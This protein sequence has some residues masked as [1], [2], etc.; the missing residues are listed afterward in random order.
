MIAPAPSA[1]T[2]ERRP[3]F[4][5]LLKDDQRFASSH[6]DQPGD[7]LNGW[8]DRLMLQSGLRTPPSLWLGLC[9]LC[10]LALGGLFFVATEHLL[11]TAL[12]GVVG[13]LIPIV[14]AMGMRSRR[15]KKVLDQ[16]PG[17]AEELARAAR[18]GRN[19]ENAFQLVAADTPTPLGDELRMAMRRHQIGLDLAS[20][21]RDLPQRT[22]VTACTMLSSAIAVHQDTGG[23][24]VKVLERLASAIRDRIHFVS[25]LRAAT[26]ASRLVAVLMAVIPLVI[27]GFNL[28]R[29]P[30]YLTQLLSSNVGRLTFWL[31]IGL[32]IVGGLFVYRILQRSA[33]F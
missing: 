31:A 9:L 14:V 25:R 11:A 28:L 22:G 17:V 26:I 6:G 12:F 18:S 3:E 2:I 8:F 27:L 23:D 24:L 5:G 30:T 7:A 10:G 13:L 1:R 29:D 32:Q 15:Q 21:I 33:R 4:A 20:A 19:V 16:L